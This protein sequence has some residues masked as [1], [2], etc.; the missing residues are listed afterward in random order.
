[1]FLEQ[2]KSNYFGLKR[3]FNLQDRIRQAHKELLRSARTICPTTRI[4]EFICAGLSSKN[5]RTRVDCADF[6]T[7]IISEEG[8]TC[9]SKLKDK[10]FNLLAAVTVPNFLLRHPSTVSMKCVKLKVV[11]RNLRI[12][13]FTSVVCFQSSAC[14]Y[15]CPIRSSYIIAPA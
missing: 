2:P 4:L 5:S 7:M 3:S 14:S 10:P 13:S 1:M 9:L 8:M 11:E 15:T 6:L 12:H